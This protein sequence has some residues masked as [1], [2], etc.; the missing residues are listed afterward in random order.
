MELSALN[1]KRRDYFERH[2]LNSLDVL[3][4]M[5]LIVIYLHDIS[6]LRL[7]F[8][9][10]L[11]SLF[12]SPKS[13]SAILAI[14]PGKRYI[15]SLIVGYNTICILLHA[16]T[17]LPSSRSGKYLHGSFTI[18]FIGVEA[19]NS[20]LP[21]VCWSIAL[22]LVQLVSFALRF[23]VKSSDNQESEGVSDGRAAT[24]DSAL[25]GHL[26]IANI[27]VYRSMEA[28][29]AEPFTTSLRPRSNDISEAPEAQSVERA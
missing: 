10:A 7:I 27:Q 3:V 24:L 12:L 6:F 15:L 18:E 22:L 19:L 9:S 26:N 13:H 14:G 20:R 21:L 5:E 29:W 2:L 16:L 1:K 23:P 11:Q 8:G 4:F 17:S 25:S 28:A